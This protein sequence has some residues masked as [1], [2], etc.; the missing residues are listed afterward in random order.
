LDAYEVDILRSEGKLRVCAKSGF[1]LMNLYVDYNY[2][3]AK[4]GVKLV[5]LANKLK[6]PN[7]FV[8]MSLRRQL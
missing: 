8:L 4:I 6:S 1:K 2:T 7:F 5:A 3:L